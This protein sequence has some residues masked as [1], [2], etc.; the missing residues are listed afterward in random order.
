[1]PILLLLFASLSFASPVIVSLEGKSFNT[2]MD[3]LDSLSQKMH[4]KTKRCGG[5]I[6]SWEGKTFFQPRTEKFNINL[7][8]TIERE[9]LVHEY[10]HEVR[11]DRLLSVME[12]FSSYP[13]RFYTT[14]AGERAMLDLAEKWK[15]I[16]R[17]LNYANV[18]ILRHEKWSQPSIILTM[19]GQE[20]ESIILGGHGDS[21]N[22]DLNEPH[23]V[24]PGADDNA[25]GISV[26][27]EIISVLAEKGYR[28]K[29][30]LK[31]MAYAAE[32][33]GLMGSMEISERAVR[34]QE[35]IR[36]VL[37]FDGTNF[38]GSKEFKIVL[39]NDHTSE[40][41]NQFL[42]MILDTYLKIP[43]GYDKCGY[44]CSDH[45][46]WTYRGYPASFPFES[47]IS[48]ENS[49]IHTA[50]DTLQMMNNSAS[51]SVSF[52]KL[53]LAYVIELDK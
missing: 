8:Y 2:T 26:L 12:W 10:L 50:N 47:I 19:R 37:Q 14:P 15:K 28:P 42:G 7:N 27:T 3:Q 18:E 25:S 30:T 48:E 40:K 35:V 23:A 53:G 34:N 24:A 43:W 45:Y 38:P 33:V 9:N 20:Q 17:N 51:H 1:M 52:A 31:F 13:T 4:A 21:I 39:V 5:F 6:S 36:G 22:T 11:E 32:E 46:S 49:H 44:A 16:V 29:H 41:Q